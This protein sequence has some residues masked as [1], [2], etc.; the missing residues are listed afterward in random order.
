[1]D[2][3]QA[4]SIAY[5]TTTAVLVV[6]CFV[7]GVLGALRRPPFLGTATHLGYPAYFMTILGVCYVSAGLV[8][9]APRLPRLKEWAYAGLIF[10]YSGAVVSHLWVGDGAKALAGPLVFV[11]LTTASWALRS[12]SRCEFRPNPLTVPGFSTA[13]IIGYWI[14]TVP[15]AA[16]LVLG[17]VWDLRRTD[18]V[19]AVVA[20]LGYPAYLL[21]IIGAW[22][23]AGVV[24]LLMPGFPRIKE[25]AY[26]GA[27]I[28]YGSATASH[29]TVGT[30]GGAPVA[31]SVLLAL[32]VASWALH[33]P[34]RNADA[35]KQILRATS[36][37]QHGMK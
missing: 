5:W 4:K 37:D 34:R 25:W 32:T 28:T 13:R 33:P 30:G 24:A 31:A 10:N 35:R 20:Q 23:L 1:M 22:K 21:T 27:V 14:T 11:G 15:V 19:R 2:T 12:R 6:E 3:A 9:L 16:E 8:L 36:T 17:G 26:A 7:G 29:L 18:E